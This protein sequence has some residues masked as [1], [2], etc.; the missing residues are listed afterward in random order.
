YTSLFWPTLERSQDVWHTDSINEYRRILTDLKNAG[1]KTWVDIQYTPKWASSQPSKTGDLGYEDYPPANWADWDDAV[2]VMAQNF[3]DLVDNWLIYNEEDG[4]LFWGGTYA[5]YLELFNRAHTALTT[6]D[7]IDAD[8]D[9]VKFSVAPGGYEKHDGSSTTDFA[10]KLQRD[11]GSKFSSVHYHDYNWGNI[12]RN[13]NMYNLSPA[14]TIY[15]DEFGSGYWTDQTQ[16]AYEQETGSWRADYPTDPPYAHENY[17]EIRYLNLYQEPDFHINGYA[18]FNFKADIDKDYD[19]L[20]AG[21]QYDYGNGLVEVE[22]NGTGGATYYFHPGGATTQHYQWLYKYNGD[23]YPVQATHADSARVLIDAV[24]DGTKI[25]I[26][27]TNIEYN[28]GASHAVTIKVPV[29]NSTYTLKTYN[30]DIEINS[31]SVSAS[32]GYITINASL[33]PSQLTRTVRYELIP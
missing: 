15:I 18:A 9:G 31:Q 26:V 21:G 3:G 27:A 6:Y 30:P 10:Y 5:Q 20:N 17:D 8:G 14:K 11:A 12:E 7:T 29:A 13:N 4:N 23:L 33:A 25:Q 1:I 22:P 24:R 16:H 2:K 19:H 28:G 32:G